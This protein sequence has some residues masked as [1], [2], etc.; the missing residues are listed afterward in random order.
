VGPRTSVSI[1]ERRR[2]SFPFQEL[3]LEK[4]SKNQLTIQGNTAP[5]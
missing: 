4:V 1:I 5:G 3:N 2:I